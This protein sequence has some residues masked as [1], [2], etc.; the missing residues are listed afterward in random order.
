[1]KSVR[2]VRCGNMERTNMPNMQSRDF[3]HTS[4]VCFTQA[5]L[6]LPASQLLREWQ[7]SIP[8][9]MGMATSG[10]KARHALQARPLRIAMVLGKPVKV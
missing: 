7:L 8:C 4:I 1:M 5:L 10:E 6:P 3:H 9:T 2:L